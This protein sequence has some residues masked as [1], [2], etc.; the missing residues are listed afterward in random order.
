MKIL[1][2]MHYTDRFAA[3]GS[4]EQLYGWANHRTLCRRYGFDELATYFFQNTGGMSFDREHMKREISNED[5]FPP[6][7][8]LLLNLETEPWQI[9]DE[10]DMPRSR[11]ID[12]RAKVLLH[13]KALRPDLR[14]AYFSQPPAAGFERVMNTPDKWLRILEASRELIE[15]QDC[16]VPHFYPRRTVYESTWQNPVELT[17]WRMRRYVAAVLDTLQ[18][19]FT[20]PVCPIVWPVWSQW[21]DD[22]PQMACQSAEEFDWTPRRQIESRVEGTVW[23]ALTEAISFR[24]ETLLLWGQG[25]CPFDAQAE[26]FR[27]TLAI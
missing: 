15:L 24:C 10:H 12:E 3:Q 25:H 16:Q 20:P 19:E 27:H 13:I 5:L 11:V 2:R 17:P 8:F 22:N 6:G 23:R 7:S 4:D 1:A 21:F 9:Y 14:V 26:W 18:R